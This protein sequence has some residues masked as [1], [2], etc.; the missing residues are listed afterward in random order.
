MS[1]WVFYSF[2]IIFLAG[3]FTM[4]L[5][6]NLV[7]AVWAFLLV[8]LCVVV[9]FVFLG[10]DFV[11][12]TQLMIYVGGVLV[13]LVFA[14]MMAGKT[15][16][17]KPF[18]LVKNKQNLIAALAVLSLA[19]VL[20]KEIFQMPLEDHTELSAEP[21]TSPIAILL[22]TKYV[23]AFEIAGILLLVALLGATLVASRQES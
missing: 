5:S 8:L 13:L 17:E 15:K 19:L 3:L 14:L 4:A 20:G 1:E 2:L 11:A 22:F 10:A 16:Q 12:T 21:T 9:F 18:I 7:Y 23:F 6:R